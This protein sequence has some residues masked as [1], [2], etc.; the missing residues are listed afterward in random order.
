MK[1]KI[2]VPVLVALTLICLIGTASAVNVTA[3]PDDPIFGYETI[4]SKSWGP[5]YT[6]EVGSKFTCTELGTADSITCYYYNYGAETLQCAIYNSSLNLVGITESQTV[7]GRGWYTFNFSDPKPSLSPG[8]YW[9]VT[10]GATNLIHTYIR[11]DAGADSQ[12]MYDEL[13]YL[14]PPS[15]S[16]ISYRANKMSIYCTYTAYKQPFYKQVYFGL[17]FIVWAVGG[18]SIALVCYAFRKEFGL[19]RG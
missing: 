3:V 19:V 6:F 15:L 13:A 4:G 8:D 14:W 10:G 17:P 12:W 7:N 2:L 11:Y 16:P 1:P 5:L 18:V 9:L